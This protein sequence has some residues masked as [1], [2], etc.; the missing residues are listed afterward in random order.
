[1]TIDPSDPRPAYQQVADRL[2]A[3]ISRGEIGPGEKL[4]SLRMLAAQYAV[5]PVTISR[6]V[7]LLKA[8][9]LVDTRLGT[10]LFVRPKR[11]VL[12]VASYLTARAD[13]S[14][15]TWSSEVDRQGYQ[16]TQ[17]ITEVGTV[18]APP[19]VAERLNL[20]AGDPTIVRRRILLVD[21]IPVQLSDSYYPASL[22]EDTEL[23][24]PGKL[25]GYTHSALERLGVE[26]DRFRDDLSLRMPTP[27]EARK[28]RLGRG[29]PVL[30]LL[31]TTYSTEGTSVEVADQILAGDRYVLSYEVPAHPPKH[32]V[33][34]Q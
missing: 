3:T 24:R 30:R 5:T 4:P 8:E 13:G 34:P 2:R 27:T 28:L 18:Q 1:M 32:R 33:E 29:I 15:A 6:A 11:P 10:G 25:R 17:E 14:R 23:S 22:A 21:D 19:D 31:R 9:G 7:D 12:Q 16:A 20:T 26:I